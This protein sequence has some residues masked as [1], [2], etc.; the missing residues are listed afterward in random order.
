MNPIQI[1]TADRKTRIKLLLNS[2]PMPMP[3]DEIKFISG[4]DRT[5]KDGHP[6]AV[7]EDIRKDIFEE[8][9][10]INK[11]AQEK[12]IVVSKM[13]ETLPFDGGRGEKTDWA[14]EVGTLRTE[15]EKLVKS[16]DEDVIK[17]KT[18]L[19][20][21]LT[22][23]EREANV[24][25][26]A[27]QAEL[28]DSMASAKENHQEFM[29]RRRLEYDDEANPVKEKIQK[30]AINSENQQKISGTM[31]FIETAKQEIKILEK[32]AKKHSDEISD[33][34]KLKGEL[35]ENLPVKGL[36][37]YDGDIYIDDVPF[38][39]L[40]EAARIRFCLMIA[41]LRKTKLPLVCVD[42]LEN[43][44]QERFKIFKDEAEK[45]DMQFFFSRV[46]EDENLTI[47]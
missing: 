47:N 42:G 41:G 22:K 11:E 20:D 32:N 35:M 9:A 27:I 46:S 28:N 30:A 21:F 37:V 33:L 6:L 14:L 5:D 15:L 7:I 25:I 43:L 10:F 31:E 29:D 26:T 13:R 39:T 24:Q 2:V 38:D 45:T 23:K 19:G 1:L 12:E 44:D 8:R 40:N 18:D 3:V 36:T 16:H 17:A 34:D 4:L